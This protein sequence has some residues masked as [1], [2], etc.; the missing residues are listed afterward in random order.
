MSNNNI[1]D[2]IKKMLG[3]SA[4]YTAFDTD[5]TLL[6]NSAI[7]GLSQLGVCSPNFQIVDGSETWNDLLGDYIQNGLLNSAIE[8]IYIRVRLVFDPPTSGYV[9]SALQKQLDEDTWRLRVQVE[10]ESD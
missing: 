1:K 6:I 5:V 8:Y 10:G 3:L 9:T 7:M 2:S 4:D